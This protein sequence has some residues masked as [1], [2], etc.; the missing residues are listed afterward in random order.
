MRRA[1]QTILGL[2]LAVTVV[3]CGDTRPNDADP[4]AVGTSGMAANADA[5]FIEEQLADGNREVV[6]GRLAAEKATN[7]QVKEFAQMMVNDHQAAGEELRQ[8]ASRSNVRVEPD[9]QGDDE[10][11]DLNEKLSKL[12]GREFDLEYINAMVEDHRDAIEAVE[13]KAEGSDNAEVKQWATKTLPKLRAHLQ[14]AERIHETLQ[15]TNPNSR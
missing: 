13:D 1:V 2:G 6:L 12:S 8:V 14:S 10:L 9:T 3:A 15:Q 4:N 5:G 11:R 7:P